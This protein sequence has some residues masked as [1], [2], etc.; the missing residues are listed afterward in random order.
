MMEVG[1]KVADRWPSVFKKSL[2]YRTSTMISAYLAN[3][4]PH[5]L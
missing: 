5:I 1:V 4:C 2:G 3:L